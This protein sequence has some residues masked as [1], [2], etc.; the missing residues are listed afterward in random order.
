MTER[1]DRFQ[2]HPIDQQ[3]A[4][5]VIDALRESGINQRDWHR[6]EVTELWRA[7]VAGRMGRE[8]FLERCRAINPVHYQ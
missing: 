1:A 8:D 7:W 6:E 3:A 2:L 5:I 4:E